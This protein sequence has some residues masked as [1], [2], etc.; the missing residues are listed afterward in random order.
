MG[1]ADPGLLFGVAL[2]AASAALAEEP[3]AKLKPGTELSVT[4]A[5]PIDSGEVKAGSQVSAIATEDVRVNGAVVIPQGSRLSG[6]VTRAHRYRPA[7]AAGESANAELGIVFDRALTPGRREIALNA[8]IAAVAPEPPSGGALE[9]LG[10]MVGVPGISGMKMPVRSPGS[11]GGLDVHGRLKPGSRGVFGIENLET[12]S[13][14]SIT[15]DGTVLTSSRTTVTIEKGT[16]LLLV[17]SS[18]TPTQSPR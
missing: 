1:R 4:L 9:R 3:A 17:A 11:S 18:G 2:L 5:A 15:A 10:G 14:A 8:V 6:R 7:S 13:T 12:S 16:Q